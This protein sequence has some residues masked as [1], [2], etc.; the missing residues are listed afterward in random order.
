MYSD[1]YVVTQYDGKDYMSVESIYTYDDDGEE[2]ECSDATAACV[3]ITTCADQGTD[4]WKWLRRQVEQ[5]LRAAGISYE[6][7]YFEDERGND[8]RD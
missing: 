8:I 1:L 7:L 2:Q 5:H 3:E 4:L 6:N